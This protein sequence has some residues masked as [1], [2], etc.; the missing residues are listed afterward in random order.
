M[1][2]M[3]GDA[4]EL[5]GNS[6]TPSQYLLSGG[7]AIEICID[8]CNRLGIDA[9]F[10]VPHRAT[11][12]YIESFARLVKDRLDPRLKVYCEFSNEIWNRSFIQSR[13]ALASAVAAA[14]LEAA[15]LNPWLDKGKRQGT[16]SPERT[17]VLIRRCHAIWET[18][19][20]GPDR[21]RLI[22]VCAVQHA[23]LDASRRTLKYCLEHGGA[24]ALA[25]GGYFGAEKDEYAHWKARGAALNADE[26][27][28]H[29]KKSLRRDT[30]KW[31]RNLAALAQANSIGY[32]VYEGGQHVQP[33]GA[34]ELPY[35]PALAMAQKHLGMHELYM[36][37]FR[38][39]G[40]VGCQLFCAFSSVGRKASGLD[41]GDMPS[42]MDSR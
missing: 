12:D 38:L 17:G 9:W 32:L 30:A 26:V 23:A 39:H 20:A 35:M 15:G 42:D 36:E 24:D 11:D 6:V 22:R 25:S 2:G 37:N 33:E 14:Q 5:L 8:L 7:V 31:T 27:T 18:V 3:G 21:R 1:V 4:D 16:S 34:Q 41:R 13:W 19:F 28:A 10:C 40:E 29:L